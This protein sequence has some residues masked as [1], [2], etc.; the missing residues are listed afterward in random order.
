ML[1]ELQNSVVINTAT[2]GA[3]TLITAPTTAEG[4]GA[5]IAIDHINLIPTTAVAVTFKSSTTAV[6]G[7]YPL[8][9][10]QTITLDNATQAQ[11]GVITCDANEDFVIHLGA[12]VQIG[13]FINYRICNY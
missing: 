7:P 4:K 11:K 3:N 8:D 2:S 12:A 5:Y 1:T 10:K 6:S 9:G 13:G